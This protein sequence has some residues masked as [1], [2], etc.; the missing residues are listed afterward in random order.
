[1]QFTKYIYEH[2]HSDPFHASV[3]NLHLLYTPM[4]VEIVYANMHF[5]LAKE[6]S[7]MIVLHNNHG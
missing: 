1:M 6:I 4:A 5:K 2:V 3:N 7:S